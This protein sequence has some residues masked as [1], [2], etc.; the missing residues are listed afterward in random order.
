MALLLHHF[1]SLR[2][3][4]EDNII[5]Y[6][7]GSKVVLNDF[8]VDD[9]V[10]GANTLQEALAIKEETSQLLKEG[11]FDLRKWASNDS[12][13][14]D[15][16]SLRLHKEFIL[17]GDI[18]CETRTLGLVWNCKLD[19]FKFSSI[20]NLPPLASPT[21]RSI[22]SRIFL[23]FDPFGLLAPATVTAKIIIQD[24]WRLK[25]DWDESL[26]LNISTKWKNTNLNCQP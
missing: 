17:S 19:H 4:A 11:G 26:P 2:K 13:L 22:L 5:R 6:P 21:K 25:T 3:L 15:D 18:E 8:Y 23:I 20:L 1:R 9:L 24:L 7:I 16:Q 12:A 10:T 14:Q